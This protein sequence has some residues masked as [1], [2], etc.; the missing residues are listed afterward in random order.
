MIKQNRVF[1]A[2]S[3]DG[4]IADKNGGIDWLHSIPNPDSIDM[5]YGAFMEEID[6]I[7]MG[8]VTFETVCSF[9]ID[10]P[11]SKP[12]FVLSNTLKEIPEKYTGKAF[13]VQGT[14]QEIVEDIHSQG[15][16][17]LYID[18][19]TTIRSFLK[20]DRIQSMVI[21]IIPVLLGGGVPLFSLLPNPLEFEC[22]NS[23]VYLDKIVQNHF[24]RVKFDRE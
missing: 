6:A 12:V 5:G 13:L 21:T 2:T 20:E 22:I 8:R 9:D 4:Y 16:Y 15:Y 11:Y 18:G 1:I 23:I 14:I 10:W 19:G 3:L 7:V 17:Q 24:Q